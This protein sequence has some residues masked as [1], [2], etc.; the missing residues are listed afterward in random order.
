MLKVNLKIKAKDLDKKD[1]LGLGRSDPYVIMKAIK[2]GKVL[3]KTKHIP[4]NS[5]PEFPPVSLTLDP[6]TYNGD[7]AFQ[8]YD[9][10]KS[11]NHDFIGQFEAN[12][13]QIEKIPT[14]QEVFQCLNKSKK[15]GQ[16]TVSILPDEAILDVLPRKKDVEVWR[17]IDGKLKHED[18]KLHGTFYFGDSYVIYDRTR[19]FIYYW[20]GKQSS[21]EEHFEAERVAMQFCTYLGSGSQERLFQGG[22][23]E[24]FLSL[25]KEVKIN[26]GAVEES[27]EDSVKMYRVA[28]KKHIVYTEVKIGW[29]NMN[30]GDV[31]VLDC[32]LK[33]FVW[34]GVSSN[35][36]ERFGGSQLAGIKRNQFDPENEKVIHVTD[37]REEE[38]EE[39]EK[40]VWE[41]FLPFNKKHLVNQASPEDDQTF[42]K[43]VNQEFTIYK[44]SDETGQFQ[45]FR[46]KSGK[47]EKSDLKSED[48]FLINAMEL[49]VWVWQG[50]KSNLRE[51]AKSMEL[52]E[53]LIRFKKL[54]PST[55]LVKVMEGG[56]SPEFKSLFC[57]W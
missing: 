28:G 6:E 14:Q 25:F 10:D 7:I 30:H 49:G 1:F 35:R 4:S 41:K 17:V 37:G 29:E 3:H 46:I 22:E 19:Q 54:H 2:T 47:L 16:V 45:S 12:L 18:Y 36:V 44:C 39:D 8:V 33:I 21:K 56:E 34:S 9:W 32:G 40:M 43:K 50:K 31:F 55:R 24:A 51:R 20:I 5:N 57:K 27:K 15:A 13:A 38:M 52:G 42:D 26:S 53:M 48:V 23:T 11:G